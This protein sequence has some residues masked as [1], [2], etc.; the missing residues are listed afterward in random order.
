MEIVASALPL[1]SILEDL[2]LFLLVQLP[3]S[4]IYPLIIFLEHSLGYLG[5]GL[6]LYALAVV[7][8]MVEGQ[9]TV[10]SGLIAYMASLGI[11]I[12]MMDFFFNGP[13]EGL[14]DAAMVLGDLKSSL[15]S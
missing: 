13:G 9:L 15:L 1:S 5:T 11:F 14:A 6:F 10:T 12:D 4:L 2:E 8:F 3:G 7:G